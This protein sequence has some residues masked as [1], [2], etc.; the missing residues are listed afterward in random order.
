M[1]EAQEE[2][3]KLRQQLTIYLNTENGKYKKNPIHKT[4]TRT[5]PRQNVSM[6]IA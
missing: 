6:R 5:I 1:G 4:E 2:H 3:G